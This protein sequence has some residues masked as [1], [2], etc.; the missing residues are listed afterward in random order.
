M[1]LLK[2]PSTSD[3]SHLASP[4]T[5]GIL[6]SK[7]EPRT[8]GMRNDFSLQVP[9]SPRL[10]QHSDLCPLHCLAPQPRLQLSFRTLHTR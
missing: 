7:S 5:V 1:L 6:S 2:P 10:G 4:D 8:C 3:T 9:A